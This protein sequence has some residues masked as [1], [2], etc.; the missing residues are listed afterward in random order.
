MS[1]T[2]KLSAAQEVEVY[3][4]MVRIAACERQIEQLLST[5][6]VQFMYYPCAGQ[7]AIPAAIAQALGEDDYVLTT[8]RGIHDVVA[9]G[10]PM[11]EIMAEILGKQSGTSKGKGGPMHLSDPGSGLM[12]TTGIVGGNLPI[13]TGL[14]L[15]AKLEDEGRVAVCNFG[16]GAA[17]IGAFGESLNFASLRR[18]PVVFVCQNNLYAEYTSFEESTVSDSVAGRAGA[19]GMP[20]E[21]VDGTDPAEVYAAAA[22]AVERAR[23]GEGPTLLECVAHRLQGHYF[24]S[25]ESHMDA[26]ALAAARETTPIAE[27][28][29]RL[30]AEGRAEEA[31][32]ERIEKQAAEEAEQAVEQ[33]L[34]APEPEE[35]ELFTDVFANTDDIPYFAPERDRAAEPDLS[36]MPAEDINYCQAINQALDLAMDADERVLL[37]GEDIADPAGGVGK[38]TIGLST[39][40]GTDRVIATPIS[41]QAIV[42]SAIGAAMAGYRP[43]PEIMINDFLMVCMDQV[44][45]HAAKLR[46][47]SGGRTGVPITIRSVNAGNVGRF[48]SQHSQSLETWLAHMPGI[49][50]VVPSTAVDAK[51]LLLACIDDPD[52]CFFLEAMRLYY[53]VEPVPADAYRIPLGLAATRREGSDV[54]LLSYGWP[55][56]ECLA[57]AETLAENGTSAEVIDLRCLVPL[58]WASVRESVAKTGRA[59]IVHAATE[60]CGFGAELAARLHQELHGSLRSP[61][62]RLGAAYAPPPFALSLEPRYFPSAEAIV[63][64]V[65][66]SLEAAA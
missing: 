63:G 49:K 50:V 1:K 59:V 48:G 6:A 55:V 11:T 32:L 46:Y 45:N 40:Y 61:V 57:A 47:M 23:K 30:V 21:R 37:M 39:K 54:T 4:T 27:F 60:F 33:A 7:E 25:D 15:A 38:V 28:R 64:L 56:H 3:R 66:Q 22:V 35:G 26:E 8:Y 42:G 34:A 14:A 51:G 17:N 9:K 58:D 19:Y 12:V 36:A 20:G 10:T 29:A 41:E 65:E 44:A 5:G 16:D 18:L 2:A 52:P 31:E 13:S 24:G 53:N 43:V 62:R